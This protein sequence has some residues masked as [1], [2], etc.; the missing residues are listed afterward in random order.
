MQK[1][2][3][4]MKNRIVQVV[5]VLS[6]YFLLADFLPYS[7]HQTFYTI[8]LFIKDLLIWMMPITVGVF[9]AHAICSFQKKAPL[10]V[11][12]IV[13]F[14]AL[15]NFSC[16]W[17]SYMNAHVVSGYLP[18]VDLPVMESSFEALWRLPFVKPAFWAA[19]KGAIVG[20]LLGCITGMT[21]SII[22]NKTLKKGKLAAE[23]ILTN[24]FARLIPVFVLGFV[25]QIYQAKLVQQLLVHYSVLICWLLLFLG[26]YLFILFFIGSSGILSKSIR[27]IKNVLPAGS[28]AF[29]SGCSLSTMPWTIEGTA[30][31]LEDK[32]IAKA[33][34]PATTNIQQVGDCIINS[35]LCFIIY[36]HFNGVCPSFMI[37]VQFSLAFVVARF[38]TSA[39]LG[40]AIFLMLP[41]YETY[42]SFTPEMVM[43]ILAFNVLLD[44]IVTSSNVMGNGALCAIF[45]KT[46]L[47]VQGKINPVRHFSK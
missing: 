30:K 40:G 9:I 31:N 26:I 12:V 4:L 27:S 13:I 17:Y 18:S 32:E 36:K 14:E 41:I 22:L 39:I 45:E 10:F 29:V 5:F 11:L 1:L 19:D 7:V 38:A 28:L 33:V 24:V 21:K 2:F 6:M 37:W 46:W 34:I 42:L 35:F 47:R 44:P 16:V 20:L 23:W 25:S 8:S 43:I 15:S 3:S